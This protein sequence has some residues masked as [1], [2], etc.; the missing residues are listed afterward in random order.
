MNTREFY[1][2]L[3]LP[4]KIHNIRV[5]TF[6]RYYHSYRTDDEIPHIYSITITMEYDKRTLSKLGMIAVFSCVYLVSALLV[7]S[8]TAVT[9]TSLK[10]PAQK[11]CTS[12]CK[13]S[14][15]GQKAEEDSTD[16]A[17]NMYPLKTFF[18]KV[19][20]E[21][22]ADTIHLFSQHGLYHKYLTIHKIE[23]A[24]CLGHNVI[25][26]VTTDDTTIFNPSATPW[27]TRPETEWVFKALNGDMSDVI[28]I[29]YR[30]YYVPPNDE[31]DG[32]DG[33]GDSTAVY[34]SIARVQIDLGQK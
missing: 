27:P 4:I 18:V 30:S 2:Y 3:L 33:R 24:F 28:F 9:T 20:A 13:L 17:N 31:S 12:N 7:S 23:S 32:G 5:Y 19:P 6:T 21:K 11:K 34:K 8:T 25:L 26:K 15:G 10:S 14:D 16:G 1:V 22:E 29:H